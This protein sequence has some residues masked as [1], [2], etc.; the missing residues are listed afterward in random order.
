M[1]V[2]LVFFK[3]YCYNLQYLNKMYLFCLRYPKICS[4]IASIQ[5]PPRLYLDLYHRCSCHVNDFSDICHSFLVTKS[6]FLLRSSSSICLSVIFACTNLDMVKPRVC[7][8]PGSRTSNTAS[9]SPQTSTI[10][11]ESAG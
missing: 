7:D 11:F 5:A 2:F 6:T 1:S 3:L 8:R 10:F 9:R 4:K